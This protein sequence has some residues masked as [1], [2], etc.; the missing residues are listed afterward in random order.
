MTFIP[1]PQEIKDVI[2]TCINVGIRNQFKDFT[3]KKEY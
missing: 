3:V 1:Q 2:Y